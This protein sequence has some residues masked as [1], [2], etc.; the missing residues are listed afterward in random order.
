MRRDRLIRDC[1]A[2]VVDEGVQVG[3]GRMLKECGASANLVETR[4]QVRI[5]GW[6]SLFNIIQ[7]SAH[8]SQTSHYWIVGGP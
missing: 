5:S 6:R 1:T 8:V 2:V 4:R 3:A 7:V